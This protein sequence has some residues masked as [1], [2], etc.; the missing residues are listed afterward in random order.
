MSSFKF[1]AWPTEF[2]SINQY[3]GANPQNYAQ[4]GLPGHEGLDIM[5]PTGSKI[6]AVAPGRIKVVN[7][8][9][10]GVEVR[11]TDPGK[12]ARWQETDAKGV[13]RDFTGGWSKNMTFLLSPGEKLLIKYTNAPAW[14]WK[15]L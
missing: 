12:V 6:F 3:F 4:F 9:P 10:F 15:G 8:N 1:E 2:R 13:V 7:T 5:A 14:S 11:I